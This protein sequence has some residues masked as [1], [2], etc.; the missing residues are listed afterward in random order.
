MNHS[1]MSALSR[2]SEPRPM[3]DE[4]D[5]FELW[6]GLVAEKWT[7]VSA[8]VVAVVL[9]AVYA[10]TATPVYKST[11]YF[12]PPT[13]ADVQEMNA[14]NLMVE[15]KETSSLNSTEEKDSGSFYTP[16]SVFDGFVS[17]LNS[18]EV[19]KRVFEQFE[20]AALYGYQAEQTQAKNDTDLAALNKAFEAF[21]QDVSVTLPKKNAVGDGVSVSLSLALSPEQTADIL[22][23]MVDLARQKTVAQYASNIRSELAIRKQRIAEKIASLRDIEQDRRLDRM[24]QLQE[25]IGIAQ[26]LNQSEPMVSGPQVNIVNIEEGKNQG[27]PLYY[28]GYRFLQ[29]ELAA[30]KARQNDDPFIESLRGLQQQLSELT[31]LTVDVSKFGVV[32]VDQPA[33]PAASADRPKKALILAVAGVLGLMLGVFVALIRRAVNSRKAAQASVSEGAAV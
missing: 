25:A 9:A 5:L 8:A 19:Q 18:R 30:L 4:I 6:E 31:A 29:A 11:A 1:D 14:L 22:N 28:L 23:T 24:A 32:T 3:D 16:Q 21:S 33:L 2:S 26:A 7:L 15:K 13:L 20:L 10:W 27:L 17:H 12:L